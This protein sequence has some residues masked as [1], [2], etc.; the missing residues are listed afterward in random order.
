MLFNLPTFQPATFNQPLM[1]DKFIYS[2]W[3]SLASAL[4]IILVLLGASLF[5]AIA[6]SVGYINV[7]G[8]TNVSFDAY[9][10]T[11]A[12]NS[13]FW[14]SLGFSLWISIASTAVSSALAL[15]LAVWLSE[16]RGNMDTLALNWNLAFPHLV[17]SVALLLFLSQSGLFARWAASIGFITTTDQF[18]VLVRDRFGIGIILSYVGKEIPFLTIIVLSVL[19]SQ[20]VGYDVVAE[21]LGAS[22]W[23]RL[24]Y[25]TIPQVLPALLAGDLLVFGFI[26]SSYEVP[27]LLGVGYPRA[28]PV[29]ALRFFL[30]PDLR[31][32][33][34]GM[35]IS[36]IIT[37]IVTMV[38]VI[39]LRIGERRE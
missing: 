8:Q 19:R 17:W 21:N 7:I 13:E 14:I 2:P 16:R 29:L 27:A 22:R 6:E 26:F 5:Y 34:E 12:F 11:L 28:L 10:E 39:S 9:R 37:L 32:R 15:A 36:L 20:A 30:D 31:A 38:A 23:Q 35:V 25:V 4:I 33:S 18:P 1:R 3:I 24:R